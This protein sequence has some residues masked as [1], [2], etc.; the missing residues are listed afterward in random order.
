[1]HVKPCLATHNAFVITVTRRQGQTDLKSFASL[2]NSIPLKDPLSEEM[3]D[4]I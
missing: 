2:V 3:I 4:D 1:M